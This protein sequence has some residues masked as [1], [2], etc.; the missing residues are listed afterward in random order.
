MAA[1]TTPVRPGQVASHEPGHNLFSLCRSEKLLFFFSPSVTS[2]LT[3]TTLLSELG[4]PFFI[5]LFS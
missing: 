2:A 4:V 5:Y 3:A 1:T